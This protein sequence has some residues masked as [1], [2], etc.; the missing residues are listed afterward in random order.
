LVGKRDGGWEGGPPGSVALLLGFV[1]FEKLVADCP[2]SDESVTGDGGW[3]DE[4]TSSVVL[5]LGFV[6]EEASC[7]VR[8][9]ALNQF[10]VVAPTTNTTVVAAAKTATTMT[11][12]AFVP[13]MILF[14]SGFHRSKQ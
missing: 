11:I 12:S 6:D 5:L 7:V 2:T 1:E 14:A 9:G 4:S 10:C 13:I 3:D 8:L